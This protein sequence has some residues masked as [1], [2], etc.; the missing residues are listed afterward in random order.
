M[1]TADPQPADKPINHK[2]G[3]IYPPPEVRNIVDKTASFVARNGPDFESRIR[4]NEIN[5]PKFNF[6]TPSDP[7]HAYYQHKVRDFAEG[8]AVE[9]IGLK[10]TAPSAARLGQDAQKIIQD[11]FVP[12]DPPP[13]F[14][15]VY[16][17]PSINALDI[18]IVKL[19][20]QFVARNGKQFL[21]QLMN[22]EQRNYQFDFL[23]TQHNMFGYFTKLVEQF[24]K[25]LIPPRDIITSLEEDLKN[26]KRVLDQVKYRV[27]WHK[28]QE[29]QRRREEEAL[30]RERV[31]YA[32]IDWHDFVVVETVDFQPNETGSFPMPT[33]PE[34]VGAR[35][36]AEERGEILAQQKQPITN[37]PPPPGSFDAIPT[38]LDEEE[39]D[40]DDEAEE[41]L[42]AEEAAQAD[43]NRS[44]D[45]RREVREESAAAAPPSVPVAPA[46]HS[47]DQHKHEK[48]EQE[49]A[50]MEAPTEDDMELSDEEEPPPP[51][52]QE[53]GATKITFKQPSLPLRPAP[54]TVDQVL[55]RHDYDPKATTVKEMANQ[56]QLVSP[57]TG[58]PIP[59]SQAQK[60]IRWGLLDPKWAE[61]R[62]REIAEKRE[63][64][65][66]YATGSLIES[67]LKQLAKRRTD[68]FGV[69]SEETQI[70]KTLNDGSEEE[71]QQQ[72]QKS[73]KLIWDGHAMSAETVQQRARDYL[74]PADVQA[75]FEA[76]Q[77]LEAERE[78]IGVQ[79]P[80]QPTPPALG[81]HTPLPPTISASTMMMMMNKAPPGLM[82]PPPTALQPSMFPPGMPLPPGHQFVPHPMMPPILPGMVP[83][84]PPPPLM[85]QQQQQQQQQQPSDDEPSE[86]KR[87][88]AE[89]PVAE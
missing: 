20:A 66:V 53:P 60:H 62:E 79:V 36:I 49:L 45:A 24:T 40:Y 14:E 55:I 33:T 3:I 39:N 2:I 88:R 56:F 57:I 52:L 67:S 77:R 12:K 51:P 70:G 37:V 63:Q 31:A 19:T 11:I 76:E 46:E 58:E 82:M 50:D 61:Q 25:V 69:G 13:E 32:M 65:Q 87:P 23:R 26:P 41:E 44:H 30:E 29:R 85:M 81:L 48:E 84:P 15:F 4:Q 73:D 78:K 1:S 22:R 89:T 18:D 83:P 10:V 17:P 27:E 74:T 68:I 21:A 9:T 59:A 54:P 47:E 71:Q 38:D 86:A 42:E 6:L 5:N 72:Q 75:H 7:Y 28:Y 43:A 34:E 8:K 80:P 16:D 64:D 35:A